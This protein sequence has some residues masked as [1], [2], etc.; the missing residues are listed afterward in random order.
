[1]ASITPKLYV[2]Q[3]DYVENITEK[4]APY[5]AAHLAIFLKQMQDGNLVIGGAV[6]QPPTGGLIVFRNLTPKDIEEIVQQDPYYV[7]GLVT[8]YAIKPFIA[9]TGDDS[10]KNDLL[11]V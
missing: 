6:D 7:N 3:Y 2:L 9:V 11:K 5:R 8:K 4:R 10:L 1:M